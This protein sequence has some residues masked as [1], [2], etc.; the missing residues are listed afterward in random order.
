MEGFLCNTCALTGCTAPPP[1]NDPSL[2][3][4]ILDYAHSPHCAITGGY[5]YRGKRIGFL[6]G[7]Y[8]YGDLCSG[9]LWWAVQN[10]GSWAAPPFSQTASQLQTFGQDLAGELYVGRG[11]GSVSKIVPGP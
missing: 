4:P 10:G 11:D 1:C 9:T 6:R 8:L 2:T 5:V 3:L 7:K